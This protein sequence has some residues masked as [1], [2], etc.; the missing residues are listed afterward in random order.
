MEKDLHQI[1]KILCLLMLRDPVTFE[2]S[3]P[4]PFF[5][6]IWNTAYVATYDFVAYHKLFVATLTTLI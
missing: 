1:N 3:P 6:T 2:V 4:P 5:I